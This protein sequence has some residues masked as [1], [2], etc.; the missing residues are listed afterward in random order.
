MQWPVSPELLMRLRPRDQCLTLDP[1]L[2]SSLPFCFCHQALRELTL[3]KQISWTLS[4]LLTTE[5]PA[6][7]QDAKDPQATLEQVLQVLPSPCDFPSV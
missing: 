1:A 2:A 6:N 5:H 7:S 4:A 3:V